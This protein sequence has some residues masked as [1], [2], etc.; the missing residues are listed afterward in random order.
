MSVGSLG[1]SWLLVI[2]FTVWNVIY[3]VNTHDR[4]KRQKLYIDK[5]VLE[6]NK[7]RDDAYEL[8][9]VAKLANEAGRTFMVC[10]K[11]NKIRST[12]TDGNGETV[13]VECSTVLSVSE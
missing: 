1:I 9:K 3:F 6:A 7:I 2:V 4:R 11:C 10:P 5:I 13:C 12:F 8:F